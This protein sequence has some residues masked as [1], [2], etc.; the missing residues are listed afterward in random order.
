[1]NPQMV[2]G[3]LA[4]AGLILFPLLL[5]LALRRGPATRRARAADELAHTHEQIRRYTADLEKT[6]AEKE[7][8]LAEITLLHRFVSEVHDLRQ[9]DSVYSLALDFA[10]QASEAP[11]A[12]LCHRREANGRLTLRV[13]GE[14]P[15]EALEW[16]RRQ[17]AA[18][19]EAGDARFE[20]LQVP[21]LGTCR[22]YRFA[23]GEP[24]GARVCLMLLFSLGGGRLGEDQIKVVSLIANRT[25]SELTLIALTEEL[26]RANRRLTE[27]NNQLRLLIELEN[28]FSKAFLERR[29]LPETFQ[30][31]HEIM[32]KEIFAVDRINLFLPNRGTGMLE[33]ATSVGIGDYPLEKVKVP[34]DE[35]GGALSLAFREGRSI[36]FDG[37]GA[38]PPEYRLAEPFDSIPPIRSRIFLIVPILD[39]Q[40]RALGIIASDRKYSHKPITPET[41]MMLEA[42]ARHTALLFS[43]R[44]KESGGG[45]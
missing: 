33:A 25:E 22:G 17:A 37:H 32:A 16:A 13:S 27:G 15:P 39:H 38:V 41:A 11:W 24:G 14:A 23:R 10:V 19:E 7:K 20:T 21:G 36:A 8:R 34:L 4:G 31:L 2:L 35:R 26:E 43:L 45:G 1:M 6:H 12:F 30:T 42:F 5:L 3:L 9:P 18:G 44:K 28:E 29:D 40:G